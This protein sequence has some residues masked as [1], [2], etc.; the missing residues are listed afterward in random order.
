MAQ[1]RRMD[2]RYLIQFPVHIQ[3]AKRSQSLMTEDVSEG[4]IF[5][6]TDS[7]PPLLQLVQV[8]LILPIG[9]HALKAHGMTVHVVE[10]N[11]PK[12]RVA[13]IGVQFYALDPRTREA[14]EAF[15]RH[16]ESHCP[17]SPDQT[18]LKLRRG[19][20]P[21]PLTRR[22][23]RHTAVLEL[24]PATLEA[25][26]ELYS[27]DVSNGGMFVPTPVELLAGTSIVINV[28]HPVSGTP[29]LFEAKVLRRTDPPAGVHVELS[30]VD[31]RFREDFL[32]FVR[33]PII[34]EPEIKPS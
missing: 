16:V 24:K 31:K 8:K 9:G 33:G 1:R 30:G 5:L 32:D 7:P 2:A 23:G 12:G 13:G 3:Y 27:R 14:W 34:L 18:P 19:E 28:T 4:G 26:E 29:F 17:P 6:G 11:N 15:T 10:P 20:T 25:L 21:E 22:F